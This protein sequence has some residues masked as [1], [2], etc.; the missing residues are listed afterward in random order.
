MERYTLHFD[1][2][3]EPYNPGGNMGFG[4]HVC[5]SNSR[6]TAQGSDA[7]PAAPGNTNNIA[8]YQA[9]I[10]GLEWLESNIG[11]N[12]V[13]AVYGDSQLVIR[14]MRLDWQINDGKPYSPFA[15]RALAL[16]LKFP[17]I[18]FDWVPRELNQKADDLS[19]GK[20]LALNGQ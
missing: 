16:R 18:T 10:L 6:F 19:K 15:R 12:I 2:A 5:N 11:T 17:N 8:E 20:L 7:V 3:C 14:Q 9:L 13:L 1:G 4:W